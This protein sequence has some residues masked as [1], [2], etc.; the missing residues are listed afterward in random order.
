MLRDEFGHLEHANLALAVKYR[1]ERVVGVDHD[2]F[3][4]V[5]QTAP[6]DVCPKL[7]LPVFPAHGDCRHIIG[8]SLRRILGSCLR[9]DPFEQRLRAGR[10]MIQN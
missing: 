8:S 7:L 10:G 2:S 3:L 9:Y 4:F 6:L 5:L 1:P